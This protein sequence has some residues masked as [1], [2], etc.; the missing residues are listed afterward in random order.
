MQGEFC[1]S[2]NSLPESESNSRGNP[3]SGGQAPRGEQEAPHLLFAVCLQQRH[4]QKRRLASFLGLLGVP[5]S[6]Q[7]RDLYQS[8]KPKLHHAPMHHPL[9]RALVLA[10]IPVPPW[11]LW[12][13]RLDRQTPAATPQATDGMG[14][15]LLAALTAT[16]LPPPT[17]R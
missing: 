14:P 1:S 17:T 13:R 15:E 11:Y 10:G 16:P 12:M 3:A 4:K 9:W 2:E 5:E 7:L 8:P 6:L